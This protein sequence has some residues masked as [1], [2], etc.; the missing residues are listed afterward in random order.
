MLAAAAAHCDFEGVLLIFAGTT[1]DAPAAA[2]IVNVFFNLTHFFKVVF[3]S[4]SLL[5]F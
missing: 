5:D 1:V 4:F 3:F 2:P